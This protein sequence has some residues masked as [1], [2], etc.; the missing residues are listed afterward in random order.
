MGYI[1]V[2]NSESLS[3]IHNPNCPNQPPNT[4]IRPLQ[5]YLKVILQPYGLQ[6]ASYGQEYFLKI[7]I[8]LHQL[9]YKNFSK[10]VTLK[11]AD[12]G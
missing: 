7:Q 5:A 12:Y 2:T 8:V 9:Q 1:W 6:I 10:A 11:V 4:Q 3:T